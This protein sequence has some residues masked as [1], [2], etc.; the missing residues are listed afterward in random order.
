LNTLSLLAVV[1]V[2]QIT[3]F[4]LLAA[5][6]V[7]IVRQLDWRLQL[8]HRLQLQSVLVVVILEMEVIVHLVRSQQAVVDTVLLLQTQAQETQVEAVEE[9]RAAWLVI[10]QQVARETRHQLRLLKVI[11][12]VQDLVRQQ[13]HNAVQAVA[14][15][16]ALLVEMGQTTRVAMVAQVLTQIPLGQ[17]QL[18]QA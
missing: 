3:Q 18:Q 6:Q 7:V 16:R 9:V 15:A 4:I 8:D 5:V 14:V 17:L 11:M 2:E 1:V 13:H 10:I 12:A